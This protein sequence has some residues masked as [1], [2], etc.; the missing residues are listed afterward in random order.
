MN[1]P[2]EKDPS[3]AALE[4]RM[5]ELGVQLARIEP[6]LRAL[7]KRAPKRNDAE[8]KPR[9]R[10]RMLTDEQL[11]EIRRKAHAPKQRRRRNP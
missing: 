7:V 4:Q 8:A 11:A 1:G 6:L 3:L 5:E 2:A 10:A 9:A